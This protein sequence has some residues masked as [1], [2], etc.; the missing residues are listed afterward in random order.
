MME[1]HLQVEEVKEVEEVKK[2]KWASTPASNQ[3][4]N[5]KVALD[6]AP[7][8]RASATSELAQLPVLD[9]ARATF[10]SSTCKR[11]LPLFRSRAQVLEEVASD[12][13]VHVR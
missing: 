3:V 5:F 12:Q 2:F 11:A 9:R 10:T 4:H 7:S 1:A 6:S 8:A 13:P